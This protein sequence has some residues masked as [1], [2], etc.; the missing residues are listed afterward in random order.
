MIQDRFRQYSRILTPELL[1]HG[2]EW[3]LKSDK[4]Y[5]HHGVPL[6]TFPSLMFHNGASS[7]EIWAKIEQNRKFRREEEE[8]RLILWWNTHMPHV[9]GPRNHEDT[10]RINLNEDYDEYP[11][12]LDDPLTPERVEGWPYNRLMQEKCEPAQIATLG[13]HMGFLLSGYTTMVLLRKIFGPIEDYNTP[14]QFVRTYRRIFLVMQTALKGGISDF[15]WQSLTPPGGHLVLRELFT[16]VHTGLP[17]VTLSNWT[18]PVCPKVKNKVLELFTA[19]MNAEIFAR[20]KTFCQTVRSQVG[21]AIRMN[22][23]RLK[24]LIDAWSFPFS[25]YVSLTEEKSRLKLW[26]LGRKTK[27]LFSQ[28]ADGSHEMSIIGEYASKRES[29][30]AF[31]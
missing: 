22:R 20:G 9:F 7:K 30:S 17:S 2:C 28:E 12:H 6:S 25:I 21:Q 26:T 19:A 10:Y 4:S 27:L 31:I 3:V 16:P 23:V 14:Q 18:N 13:R 24:E 29:R 8:P 1:E 11:Q 15:G 5:E